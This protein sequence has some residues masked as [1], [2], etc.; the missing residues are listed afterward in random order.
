MT[1]LT[2]LL[3]Q[4]VPTPIACDAAALTDDVRAALPHVVAAMRGIDAI[5]HRQVGP[6][7][8]ALF[9]QLADQDPS[10]PLARAVKHFNGPYNKLAG[11]AW[12]R[13]L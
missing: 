10:S 4:F 8:V 13:C 2:A 6:Q 1:D 3:D 11:H 7:V 5:F 12:E 9:E